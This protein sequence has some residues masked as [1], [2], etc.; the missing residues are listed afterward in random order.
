[1]ANEAKQELGHYF[2]QLRE[3]LNDIV[4]LVE[5]MPEG[6]LKESTMAFYETSIDELSTLDVLLEAP[7]CNT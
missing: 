7:E 3:K 4:S 6:P 1:M 5:T 2:H